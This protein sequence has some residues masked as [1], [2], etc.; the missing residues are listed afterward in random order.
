MIFLNLLLVAAMGLTVGMSTRFFSPQELQDRFEKGQKLYAL[1]DYQKAVSHYQAI[2]STES[3]SMID[4]EDVAVNVDEFILPVQ[5]AATYQLAN[6]HNKL[7]LE[8]LQRSAFLRDEQKEQLAQERYEEALGDLGASLRYFSKLVENE[9]VDGRTRVMAQYQMLETSYQLKRYEQVLEQGKTLLQNFPNSVYETSAYYNMGWSNFE[10]ERYTDAIENYK[11]VLFLSPRGSHSDRSLLQMAECHSRLGQHEEA[12]K[13]LDRLIRRYDFSQMSEQE[14]IE[15]V[16]LKL[17]GLAKETTR[18]LVAGA[19]LKKGDIFAEQG[20]VEEALAAYAV[21]PAQYETEARLVQNSYIRSAE[22]IHKTRGTQAALAAYKNAIENVDDKQF[23]ARTQ[24]TV[25]WL[26]FEDQEYAKAGDEYRIFLKAYGDVASRVG[27]DRDKTLFRIGQCYQAHGQKM[28]GTDEQGSVEALDEAIAHYH[29]VLDEYSGSELIPDALFGLGFSSQLKKDNGGA[30]P[31]YRELVDRFADNPAAPRGLLQLAR[32]DYEEGNLDEARDTYLA[33]LE[34]YPEED[35]L[36]S[37]QMEL[38]IIYKKQ[39]ER[40]AAIA[41]FGAVE[42]DF[43]HWGKMQVERAELYVQQKEEEQAEAVLDRAI[44]RADDD[45]LKGQLHYVKGKIRFNGGDFPTAIEEFAQS[46]NHS[47]SAEVFTSSLFSRG[48]A[49]YELAKRQDAAGDSTL[50]RPNYQA[51]LVD[52]KDLLKRDIPPSLRDGAFRTL[53]AGMIRLNQ[54]REAAQ[55]YQELIAD[56]EDPQ[57]QATFQMLLTELYYDKQD[58]SQAKK[59]ARQLL[60]MEFEDDNDAGYFRKERAYSIIGNALLQEKQYQEA[61]E[62]FAAG[63]KRYPSSGE[64]ANMAFSKAFAQF[65]GEDYETAIG[66]F[67]AY[68]ADYPNN[69]NSLHGHYYLAHANQVL[70]RYQA[71]AKKFKLL[72]E[73]YPNSNY[74]EEGLYLVGENYYNERDFEKAVEAYGELL[75]KYPQGRYG[76]NA[77]YALAWSYFELERM[78]EGVEAMKKL[79]QFY[80]QNEF[81]SKA[82]FTVGDFYYNIRS[83]EEARVAYLHLLENYPDAQETPRARR[84]VAELNE[85]QATFDYAKVMEF[86]EA[87][88]YTEAVVGFEEIVE[89][90]PDTYTELAAYCN[91]GLSYEIMRRWKEAADNYQKIVEKGGDDPENADVVGFAKLHRDWI[92]ENRL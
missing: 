85:I 2:L 38:G 67:E 81:A 11:Q 86:F 17:Q 37:V 46:L 65:N 10:L 21:V 77:T 54:E 89:K 7:G 40:E 80:P 59:F 66:S 70:T 79:V 29:Q 72:A 14:I 78:E 84:L 75:G 18:E 45:V 9:G 64:S 76:A 28:R 61:A 87:K 23:Q 19:Q 34:R 22:L 1:G 50:A 55:Y 91:L 16:S 47:P 27:F 92:V 20:K 82:Q 8:K 3:N 74:E 39:G 4:V 49:Y 48:A 53:G 33:V 36:N 83:Y 25:A 43:P 35:L 73:R 44:V 13:H 68:L 51:S 71:A 31:P 6:T 41:A 88:N 32:I 90:Y 26:L 24:L 58:F 62:V 42:E 5:V 56:S 15:M 60:D 57:E 12:I 63:L 69:R 30:R 52:M